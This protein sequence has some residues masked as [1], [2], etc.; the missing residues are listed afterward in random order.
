MSEALR[1]ALAIIGA[2]LVGWAC[3]DTFK[4]HRLARFP[5]WLVLTPGIVCLTT[6]TFM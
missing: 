5:Q 1:I 6:P 2:L 4:L 3:L